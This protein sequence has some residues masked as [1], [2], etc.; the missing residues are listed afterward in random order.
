M[1]VLEQSL[2]SPPVVICLSEVVR[3]MCSTKTI[4]AAV[5]VLIFVH[6]NQ[7]NTENSTNQKL[8]IRSLRCQKSL[9]EHESFDNRDCKQV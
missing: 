8:M 7:V 1:I 5:H 6:G 3:T 4:R 9:H 2:I